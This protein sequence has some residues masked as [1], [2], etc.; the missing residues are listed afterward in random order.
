[1]PEPKEGEAGRAEGRRHLGIGFL[2][3]FV[4]IVLIVALPQWLSS[5]QEML[6]GRS[7][8]V[9]AGIVMLALGLLFLLM[10]SSTRFSVLFFVSGGALLGFSGLCMFWSFASALA[11]QQDTDSLFWMTAISYFGGWTLVGIGKN[12]LPR[13]VFR[14][15]L[16]VTVV[17]FLVFFVIT[18]IQYLI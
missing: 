1:M 18:N 13:A 4:G 2:M 10:P 3:L 7:L 15:M 12:P 6:P 8:F 14:F 9:M 16:K 11:H 5:E 17:T